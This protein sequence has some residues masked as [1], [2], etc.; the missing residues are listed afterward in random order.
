MRFVTWANDHGTADVCIVHE[1]VIS[2]NAYPG[3]YNDS[4]A[5]NAQA[6]LGYWPPQ[7]EWVKQNYPTKP[8]IVSETGGGGLWEWPNATAPAPGPQWSLQY[9][10]AL[11]SNDVTVLLSNDRVSG[12]TL[13]QFSD[14]KAN[15]A[16]TAACGGGCDYPHNLTVPWDCVHIP[17]PLCHRPKGE[18]NKGTVDMWRRKKPVF[19][20]VSAMYKKAS[21]QRPL[22]EALRE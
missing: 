9:Q 6:P 18:N 13:W 2:F 16:D 3:W 11:V 22:P 20:F 4:D 5:G 10:V 19:A 15:D 8:F 7:V 14:I 1:D 17:V 12:L 21:A